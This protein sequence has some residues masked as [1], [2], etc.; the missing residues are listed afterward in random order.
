MMMLNP[1]FRAKN[2]EGLYKKILKGQFIKID[3]KFSPEIVSVTKALLTVKP[4]F[5]PTCEQILKMN[6]LEPWI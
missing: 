5:R 4:E 2:M 6:E 1:P 3:E